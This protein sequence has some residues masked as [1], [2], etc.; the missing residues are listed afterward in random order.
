MTS[1]WMQWRI[2]HRQSKIMLTDKERGI[3]MKWYN[4]ELKEGDRERFRYWLKDNGIKYE[5]SGVGF[6]WTHFEVYC[7]TETAHKADAFLS[8]L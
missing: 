8:T 3:I 5:A 6:G 2:S 1:L 4:V 7:D